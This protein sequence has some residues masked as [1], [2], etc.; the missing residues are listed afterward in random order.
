LEKGSSVFYQVG[1]QS[2]TYQDLLN[3]VESRSW[4]DS[5]YLAEDYIGFITNVITAI[6]LHVDITLV[7]YRNQFGVVQSNE[8][9]INQIK[10]DSVEDL[11]IAI[12]DS[13]SQVGIYSSGS[14]GVP[15]LIY[16]PVSRLL[17]S[18][19][20]D[21]SYRSSRWGFTYNPSHSAGIQVFLQVICNRG[22]LY[23][24]YKCDRPQIL[25]TISNHQITH[26]SATPTFYRM[27]AP[28]DFE[29]T[30]IKSLTFNGEK[31]TLDLINQIKSNCPNARIRN[32]YGSTESG[33]LMSSETTIFKVP[34]RL[35]GKVKV[36][37]G[38]L[39]IKS[40]IISKSVTGDD[41][42]HTGDLVKV[43]SEEPLSIEF[44]TRKSNV[45]N[46]GGQNVN[47]QEVEEVLI[48][49]SNVKDCRVYGR[50][51]KLIG[52]LIVADVQLFDS[53]HFNEKELINWCKGHLATYKVP[54]MI[55]LVDRIEV[56]R[57]GKKL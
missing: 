53:T 16:Q 17:N 4:V 45:L 35:K 27:L 18:V 41:W 42:Y 22:T 38:E 2:F 15:K 8:I 14:T 56:G 9:T 34:K 5:S 44:L 40:K 57:T 51:N 39:L 55:K 12:K 28:Y 32:I 1:D 50:K 24:L 13:K 52:N 36:E 7:D 6:I 31:S 49:N 29:W 43:V 19:R 10:L 48:S 25:D 23:D 47:P 11:I 3:K 30:S 46:V 33:P 21:E 26:L 20:E 54:R 37:S